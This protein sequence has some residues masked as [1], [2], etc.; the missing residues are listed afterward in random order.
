MP[1]TAVRCPNCKAPINAGLLSS[2]NEKSL[3]DRV[4]SERLARSISSSLLERAD[5]LSRISD[6]IERKTINS[7]TTNDLQGAITHLKKESTL[8]LVELEKTLELNPGNITL[9]GINLAGLLN[10]KGN[11]LEI[12]KKGLV[13]L[14]HRKYTEAID[15]WTLNRQRIDSRQQKLQFILFIMEAFTYALSGDKAK[16][17]LIR[18]KIHNHY[19]YEKYKIH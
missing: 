16:A 2:S 15:W 8:D 17:E 10:G 18:K 11:D 4:V 3:L 5:T 7:L 9:E 1:G 13:F 12:L 6:E 19:L 14:K